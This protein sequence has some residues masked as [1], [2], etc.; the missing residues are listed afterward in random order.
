[1]T[2]P[3][4]AVFESPTFL[5]GF[6]PG[7]EVA[8]FHVLSF[9]LVV[10][11]CWLSRFGTV[12]VVVVAAADG[13]DSADRSS[14]RLPKVY[15]KTKNLLKLKRGEG[16][17]AEGVAVF[18]EWEMLEGGDATSQRLQARAQVGRILPQG[19]I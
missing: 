5:H 1:V 2:N 19:S 8:R 3:E 17:A 13:D 11:G 14:W 15:H 18:C 7:S 10:E 6:L 9:V 12:V 16:E 4:P